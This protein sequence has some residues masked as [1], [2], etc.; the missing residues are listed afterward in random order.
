MAATAKSRRSLRQ[1]SQV[2]P[3]VVEEADAPEHEVLA[4]PLRRA[5][6]QSPLLRGG[7]RVNA[8]RVYA[9]YG[10]VNALPAGL[11]RTVIGVCAL[12]AVRGIEAA[13]TVP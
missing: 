4:G 13:C 10:P 1:V 3:A 11:L 7:L 12:G 2:P 8:G 9:V 6:T 5:Y